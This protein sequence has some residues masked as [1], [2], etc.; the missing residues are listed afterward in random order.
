MPK[1]QPSMPE[2]MTARGMQSPSSYSRLC[3]TVH[4]N[5]IAK[6]LS[7]EAFT[8]SNKMIENSLDERMTAALQ[9]FI[10]MIA[11]EVNQVERVDKVL[12][13]H[14]LAK[15][16]EILNNQLD[17]ILH[18]PDF[19]RLESIWRSLK[20]LVDHVDFRAN[21][22][23]EILDV[24]KE[25]VRRDFNDAADTTQSGIYQHIY[26]QE[27][28]TP[29][30]EPISVMIS[31]Y[32]FDARAT[33][34]TLLDEFSKVAAVTHCPFIGSIGSR[35]FNKASMDEV[36]RIDDLCNYMERTE[37]VRWTSFREE[38]DARYV[39]LTLP[40]FLLRLPY[41]HANL[42]R[43]FSYKEKVI[44][45]SSENYLWGKASF[46]FATNMARSFKQHGWLVNVRG[47]ESGGKVG[48]LPLHQ[49]DAGRELLT[50]IPTETII[51]ETRE[52]EFANLGFIPLSYY[53]NSDFACFFSANS[54]QK[55]ILYQMSE[56]TANS[57]IN[58]RLP[59]IFLSSR[60]AH[61]LKVLQRENIGSNKNRTELERELNEWM[62]TLVTKMNSPGPEL[63]ATHPLRE[64]KVIVDVI[65][66][67]PGFYRMTL[68]I[69]PHFQIEGVDVRLSL[70]AQM[71]TGEK[72]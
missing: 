40:R 57:R 21:I 52:L 16:D 47:P 62:Q 17:A 25:T 4:I 71:P 36:I 59:Y 22:K 11:G 35:F 2:A 29:G 61:Y 45:K 64:G 56:A 33:D 66:E 39:G 48:S 32:E 53:K 3:Q 31:D 60:I 10:E 30:G 50:K 34:I 13:D 55:P 67:N 7:L 5:P 20:Y 12:L 37:Y 42:V 46:A 18:H 41:S 27:Y 23:V 14:Y 70:V 44:G 72:K 38:E 65:P 1:R 6:K 54:C 63:V 69:M 19:Q 68:L 24:D 28:D 9:I 15:I 58:A 26:V 8:D 49:Y 43:S 51:P